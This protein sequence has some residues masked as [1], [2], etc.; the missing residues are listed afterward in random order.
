[1]DPE[2]A[3]K[4]EHAKK[5][6]SNVIDISQYEIEDFLGEGGNGN[7]YGIRDTK[8]N[9]V[10]AMKV[11]AKPRKKSRQFKQAYLLKNEVEVQKKFKHPN[12]VQIEL[13]FDTDEYIVIIME[14]CG[15]NLFNIAGDGLVLP[16]NKAMS[17]FSQIVDATAY[18]HKAGYAHRDIKLSNIVDCGGV[19]KIIDF[20]HS[21]PKDTLIEIPCCTPNYRAPEALRADEDDEPYLGQPTDIWALG[22]LLYEMITGYS[23][24]HKNTQL[25]MYK[26]IEKEE[27][28]YSKID[29]P[30]IIHLLKLMLNKDPEKRAG[31]LQIKHSL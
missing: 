21:I 4:V 8:T 10:Y 3:E 1:M 31:I 29:D 18:I 12:I 11:I 25:Q 7:V 24:F 20:G 28:D 5:Y 26:A 9:K 27:P 2:D 13:S 30:K 17:I 16:K 22:I 14:K 23:P 15:Y 19:W 6:L